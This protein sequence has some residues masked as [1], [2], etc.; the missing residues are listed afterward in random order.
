MRWGVKEKGEQRI[1]FVIRAASGKEPMSQLCREYEIS[2]PTGYLWLKRYREG[3]QTLVAVEERSRRPKRSPFRTEAGV[4]AR[5]VELRK[6]WGWGAKAI[7][8]VLERDEGIRLSRITV[9]RILERYGQIR[10]QDR[11]RPATTRFERSEPNQLWQMDFK[12]QFPMGER[13]C[14]PLSVLDDHSRY[15]VGLQALTGTGTEGVEHTLVRLFQDNGVPEAMLMDHGVPWWNAINGHG[16]TRLSVGLIKQGIALYFSGIGHPQTQGKVERFHETLQRA[17][18]HRNVW[19]QDLTGWQRDLHDIREAYNHQR[20][21]EALNMEVP[22]SRYRP[23]MR[24]YQANPKEW[25]YPDNAWVIRLN[26]QGQW[27]WKGK[28]RFVCRALAGERVRIQELDHHLVVSYRHMWIRQL[29]LK[30]G[31]GTALVVPEKSPVQTA[32][33]MENL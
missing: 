9:H 17:V 8:H 11:H 28:Y 1:G 29:N 15:L 20:P 5:V 32:A 22:A 33:S 25:D 21:H 23:S 14:F 2:R 30:T 12:G 31:R 10:D 19:P 3:E 4:E 16:L 13:Q 24:S 6:Q 27:Y 7:R 18:E 26:N